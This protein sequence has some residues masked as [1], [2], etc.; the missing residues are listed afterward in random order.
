ME[1]KDKVALKFIDT[2]EEIINTHEY[3]PMM[4]SFTEAGSVL[5]SYDEDQLKEGEAECSL[6]FAELELVYKK[7]K[8]RQG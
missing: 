5:M 4:I 8:E 6:T 2:G 3:D 7:A 1:D